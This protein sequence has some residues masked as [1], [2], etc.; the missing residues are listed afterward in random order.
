MEYKIIIGISGAS[1]APLAILLLKQLKKIG[2]VETHLV[3]TKGGVMTI[4]EECG[5]TARDVFALADVVYDNGNIG[6]AIASGT[7]KTSAMVVVPCSMKTVAGIVSGY[8]D[9]L[10]LRAADVTL[11]ERRKLILVPRECPFGTIHLRNLYELSQM[12][13]VVIPPMLSYYNH[14]KSVEDCS[15]HIVGK[16]MDQ[17]GL[18]T[19]PDYYKR[20]E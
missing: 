9:N 10:L 3:V 19:D 2:T 12:G 4:E 6:A 13:A 17:L 18:P 8:S 20:W 16:I 1:G 5:C 14:P 7:F 15:K 11:K